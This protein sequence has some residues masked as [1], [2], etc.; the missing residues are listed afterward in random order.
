L[1]GRLGALLSQAEE[2]RKEAE[3][4]S[5]E[6]EEA[7]K[8]VAQLREK[9]ATLEGQLRSTLERSASLEAKWGR[10]KARAAEAGAAEAEL[11]RRIEE[12]GADIEKAMARAKESSLKEVEAR[13]HE[14]GSKIE[15]L[16]PVNLAAAH[17]YKRT[18]ERLEGLLA[19]REDLRRAE[20]ELER[21]IREL[22]RELE[23][24]FKE[25]LSSV[26]E[27][28]DEIFKRLFGGGETKLVET[29]PEGDGG[30]P[31]VDIEVRLPARRR[32]NMLALS[33]GERALTALAFL[34][35]LLKVR[36]VPFCVLD[37]VDASL[38]DANTEK[39]VRMLGEF[40][41]QGTQFIIVTHNRGTMEVADALYGITMDEPGVSKVVS[42]RLDW[43]VRA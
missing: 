34:F 24:R 2:A 4:L 13:L 37:E 21:L 38:D 6:A 30:E 29:E 43:A 42:V 14:I 23:R 35:A 26:A 33:G 7:Q 12:A 40:A 11:R 17:E 19:Q 39:F 28:F 27:A 1:R 8:K 31:G 25:A 15:S 10:I 18:K 20:A 3:R 41:S 36:P 32:Q 22:D 16:G 9:I 5:G